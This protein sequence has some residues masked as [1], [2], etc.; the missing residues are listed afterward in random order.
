[1]SLLELRGEVRGEIF[2]YQLLTYHLRDVKH[3]RAKIGRLL[4]RGEIIRVKKG[5][6]VFGEMWRRGSVSLEIAAN[7]IYGPSCISF[8]YALFRYGMIAD[9]ATAITS[10]AIGRAREYETP[11]GIFRYRSIDKNKFGVGIEYRE[12]AGEGGFFIASRE[13]ALADVVSRI[14]P[15]LSLS[16]LRFHLFEELRMDEESFRLLDKSKLQEIGLVYQNP[17]V[18]K[19]VNL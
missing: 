8:E 9:R 17:L 13:K 15:S 18:E 1:M 5:L 2:D 14:K 19:L 3:P 16:D 7:L 11:I 10:L 4:K 6:Y 12:I